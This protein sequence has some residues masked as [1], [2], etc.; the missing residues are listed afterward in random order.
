MTVEIQHVS[1][2]SIDKK[3]QMQG[4][5]KVLCSPASGQ[6]GFH[7]HLPYGQEIRQIISQL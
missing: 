2:L 6:V 3:R 7:C 5:K 4:L 1:A